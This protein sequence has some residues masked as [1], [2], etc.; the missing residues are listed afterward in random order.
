MPVLCLVGCSIAG[1]LAYVEMAQ[2]TAICGP[3]GDC[4]I[5]QQSEYARMF[6][7]LPISV[8]GLAGYLAVLLTWLGSRFGDRRNSSLA[9]LSLL[10]MTLFGT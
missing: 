9:S 2:V 6:G 7:V 8:L 3:V 1:Y 4:N 5:V 10:G